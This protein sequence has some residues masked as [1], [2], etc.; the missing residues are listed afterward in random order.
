MKRNINT[1]EIDVGVVGLGLMGTSVITALLI[2]GHNVKAIA[3]LAIDMIAGPKRIKD[4][5]KHCQKAELLSESIDCYLDRLVV[6]E[7]YSRLSSCQLILECVIEEILVKEAVYKKITDEVPGDAIIASNTSA[8]PISELQKHLL[9][10][11]RFLGVHWAEPAYMTRFLEI[12]CGDQT[13]P[14]L[15]A[16]VFELAHQWS[17]EPT[18]LRKDIRGFVTNRLMYAIYREMFSLIERGEATVESVDKAFRYDAGSW[19][20]LMGVFRRL[21]FVGL[22]DHHE[23]FKNIFP[24]LCNSNDVPPLMQQMVKEKLRG[25]QDAKGLYKYTPGE[26]RAWDEAFAMFNK[27]IYKIAALYPYDSRDTKPTHDG[28]NNDGANHE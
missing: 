10:P 25:T 28:V 15:A 19:M 3:P 26:A 11:Q 23:I 21:D 6:S 20:T 5:L 4:Q 18:L 8:I 16:W 7:D 2:S 14:A 24:T 17:K 13:S 27:D 9:N 12:T 22:A 1:R